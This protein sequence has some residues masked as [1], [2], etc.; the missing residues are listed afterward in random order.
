MSPEAV[1]SRLPQ[2]TG[3]TNHALSDLVLQHSATRGSGSIQPSVSDLAPKEGGMM[4]PTLSVLAA[5][6]SASMVDRSVHPKVEAKCSPIK[7]SGLVQTGVSELSAKPPASKGRGVTQPSLSGLAA[8]HSATKGGVIQSDIAAKDSTAKGRGT[9][10]LSL[11]NLAAKH[12]ATKGGGVMQPSLS[13]LAA[14]HFVTKGGDIIQPSLSHLAAKHSPTKGGEVVQPSLS[15]LAAKHAATKGG[16][17]LPSL[18]DLAAKHS[19]SKGM[20]SSP[21]DVPQHSGEG[22]AVCSTLNSCKGEYR[23]L[24]H[25][26][27]E[28]QSSKGPSDIRTQESVKGVTVEHSTSEGGGLLG[29]IV[30]SQPPSNRLLQSCQAAQHLVTNGRRSSS[31]LTQNSATKGNGSV[32]SYHASHCMPS[33][34]PP[35]PHTLLAQGTVSKDTLH[36][37]S[38]MES[39]KHVDIGPTSTGTSPGCEL[40]TINPVETTQ[41]SYSN[42]EK[43]TIYKSELKREKRTASPLSELVRTH[44]ESKPMDPGGVETVKQPHFLQL[45]DLARTIRCSSKAQYMEG[46]PHQLLPPPPGFNKPLD[47]GYVVANRLEPHS[48]SIPLHSSHGI[49]QHPYFSAKTQPAQPSLFS[50]TLCRQYSLDHSGVEQ[51]CRKQAHRLAIYDLACAFDSLTVFSFSSPSPDDNVKQKQTEGFIQKY[52]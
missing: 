15:V 26:L 37:H 11:S 30:T 8:A 17:I 34:Q 42:L 10:Q 41:L 48:G 1:E 21:T 20:G 47:I 28:W 12:S 35:S 4:Q 9:T 49:P 3:E 22:N 33:S 25:S 23:S 29:H 40:S 2:I 24:Q 38:D 19:V 44:A 14:K 27:S 36:R 52:N 39:C 13:D 18:S 7:G 6:H 5:K 45:A 32:S 16:V 46:R 43:G 31:I 50:V 51:K